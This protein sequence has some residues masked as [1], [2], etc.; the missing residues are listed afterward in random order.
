MFPRI[1]FIEWLSV[2][3]TSCGSFFYL[4]LAGVFLLLLSARENYLKMLHLKEKNIAN[5][6]FHPGSTELVSP[7]FFVMAK[8]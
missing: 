3:R 4:R 2:S 5:L 7:S 1:K 6:H 8:K